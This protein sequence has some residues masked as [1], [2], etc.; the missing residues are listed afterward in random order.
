M[1]ILTVAALLVV[2]ALGL[3][4]N[5]GWACHVPYH[6]GPP[7]C[8]PPQEKPTAPQPAPTG[9]Q[10]QISPGRF[11]LLDLVQVTAL[12]TDPAQPV[13]FQ[14]VKVRMTIKNLSAGQL[15]VPWRIYKDQ[16]PGQSDS[17]ERS[18]SI[19]GNQ[20]ITVGYDWIA[21]DAIGQHRFVGVADPNRNLHE[22]T[23]SN[24][25][26]TASVTVAPRTIT[27]QVSHR[28]VGAPDSAFPI[29]LDPPDRPT[30]CNYGKGYTGGNAEFS[31]DGCAPGIGWKAHPEVY[32][33]TPALKNGWVVSNVSLELP[34]WASSNYRQGWWFITPQGKPLSP[35]GT[36]LYGKL[37]LVIDP[38]YPQL[39]SP[40]GARVVIT[41]TG[42]ENTNPY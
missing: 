21:S 7:P 28:D 41:I 8:V 10:Q 25:S 35:Q 39:R 9:P 13:N 11:G 29:N 36:S 18:V 30:G 19:P 16:G 12:W 6:I 33:G 2:C 5:P 34:Y 3:V 37:K 31:I 24:N 22:V 4:A 40:V 38:W 32:L 17:G 20:P 14:T 27:R 1:K 26:M 23:W 42:P 15:S